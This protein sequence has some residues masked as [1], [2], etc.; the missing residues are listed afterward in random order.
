MPGFFNIIVVSLKPLLQVPPHKDG[1]IETY[2]LLLPQWPRQLRVWEIVRGNQRS[3]SHCQNC[4]INVR[5][6]GAVDGD[7]FITTVLANVGCLVSM[8]QYQMWSSIGWLQKM[9]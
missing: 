5:Q 1:T 6:L 4:R 8:G 9:T 2:V 7:N 3:L